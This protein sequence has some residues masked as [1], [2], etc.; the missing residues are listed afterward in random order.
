MKKYLV[1]IIIILGIAFG[2]FFLVHQSDP[3]VEIDGKRFSVEVART[4]SERAI[5][6]M[7]RPS[8]PA[9]HGMIFVFEGQ[10]IRSFWMK[11]TL[12][13]LD[14]VFIDQDLKVVDV[15]K[16]IP[17]IADPCMSYVSK[18]PAKYVLEVNGGLVSSEQIIGKEVKMKLMG[19]SMR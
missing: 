12:I 17:C 9:D 19:G 3:W 6:L 1:T 4:D 13:P 16:A 2:V 14:M 7:N 8:I 11:N 18:R 10:S 5:G 15:Q